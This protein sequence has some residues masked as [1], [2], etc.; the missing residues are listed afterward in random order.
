MIYKFHNSWHNVIKK[1]LKA[2]FV[3]FE[4]VNGSLSLKVIR[5]NNVEYVDFK[6]PFH[7]ID[8]II[9]ANTLNDLKD[10]YAN[11]L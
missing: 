10:Y 1:E 8:S 4:T 6:I 11:E 3:G 5:D 7:K 2:S 9:Y